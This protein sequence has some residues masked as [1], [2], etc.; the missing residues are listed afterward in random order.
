MDR[1]SFILGAAQTQGQRFGG[2]EM[3]RLCYI[4]DIIFLFHFKGIVYLL[5]P[6]FMFPRNHHPLIIIF[7]TDSIRSRL[8][9]RQA[10]I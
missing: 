2:G 5:E 4:L 1:R 3:L 7:R 10:S 6:G 8:P 9:S